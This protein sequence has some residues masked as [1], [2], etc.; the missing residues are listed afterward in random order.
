MRYFSTCVRLRVFAFLVAALPMTAVAQPKSS[1]PADAPGWGSEWLKPA[2]K[3]QEIIQ[4]INASLAAHDVHGALDL[5]AQL[6]PLLPDSPTP[7]ILRGQA[8]EQAGQHDPALADFDRA[9]DLARKHG[10]DPIAARVCEMR[11]QIHA[12]AKNYGA[13]VDDLYAALKLNDK[14]RMALNSLAWIRAVI[15]DAAYRNGPESVRLAR[16]AVS[17][18]DQGTSTPTR[19]PPPTP[20][21]TISD[22]PSK[23]R[24]AP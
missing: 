9:E 16:R 12:R 5:C 1:P 11:A 14:D 18:P 7:Y 17:L 3:Q 15:A 19:L 22:S 13:A 21:P 10:L 24:N 4:K 8:R 6:F 20:N 2:T 23:P